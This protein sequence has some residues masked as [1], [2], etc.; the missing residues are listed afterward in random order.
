MTSNN[1]NIIEALVLSS[2]ISSFAIHLVFSEGEKW[3]T[4]NEKLAIS[5]QRLSHIVALLAQ[6]FIKYLTLNNHF[7]KLKDKIKLFSQEMFEKNHRRRPTTL[8][9]LASELGCE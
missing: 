2:I 1:D 3:L 8:Q 7:D 9:N 4:K 6:D 5:F